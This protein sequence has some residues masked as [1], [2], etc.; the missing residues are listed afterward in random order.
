MT[1]LHRLPAAGLTRPFEG[2]D[3]ACRVHASAVALQI[4]ERRWTYG[5]L[6]T[7]TSR[8]VTLL[9]NCLGETAA[10]PRVGLM[11]TGSLT[12]YGGTLAV[13]GSGAALVSL[14]AAQA[15]AHNAAIVRR[16]GIR[17]LVVDDDGLPHAQ[18]L[19]EAC[20]GALQL[21]APE[22]ILADTEGR[23]RRALAEPTAWQPMSLMADADPAC[24]LFAGGGSDD[25]VGVTID[26]GQLGT[27]LR[28]LRS[29]ALALPKDR[30]ATT[31][32]PAADGA[33]TQLLNA[34][35]SG[36]TVV[37]MPPA[38]QAAPLSFIVQERITVWLSTATLAM[39]MHQQ[40]LLQP[41][42]LP[43]LRLSLLTGGPLSAEAGEAWTAATGGGGLY[44]VGMRD[45]QP[46]AHDVRRW[47][48]P[49]VTGARQSGTVAAA[50]PSANGPAQAGQPDDAGDD[51][52]VHRQH[53]FAAAA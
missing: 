4:G 14:D 12:A 8:L 23:D 31:F 38:A 24:L 40:G 28:D 26:H 43:S 30:V 37:V 36:A 20:D 49:D 29:V 13:L 47:Q 34:W 17:W 27:C 41:G 53:Q 2:F 42:R 32:D 25:P 18:A 48:A 33:L 5:D 7:W 22:S 51:D 3:A 9:R 52:R 10:A 45:G 1:D 11:A 21:I 15:V 35:W 39:T 6:H 50:H 19:R 16:A 44:T 46:M